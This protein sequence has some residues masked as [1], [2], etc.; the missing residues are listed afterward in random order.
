MTN[1]FY[2]IDDAKH[3]PITSDGIRKLARDGTIQPD[4]LLWRE[5]FKDWHPARRIKGLF[6][7][8]EAHAHVQSNPASTPPDGPPP[9]PTRSQTRD[10]PPPLPSGYAAITAD[11]EQEL[12]SKPIDWKPALIF[13]SITVGMYAVYTLFLA[14]AYENPYDQ[15]LASALMWSNWLLL[16]A[17]GLSVTFGSILF[18]RCWSVIPPSMTNYITPG[19]AVGQLFIPFYNFYWAFI[20]YP[21]LA[22][23]VNRA[24]GQSVRPRASTG[25]ALTLAILFVAKLIL[26]LFAVTGLGWLAWASWFVIWLLF[27]KDASAACEQ[28]RL[29]QIALADDGDDRA[30]QMPDEPMIALEVAAPEA[31]NAN[32][33][34]PPAR[35][36]P[37]HAEGQPAAKEGGDLHG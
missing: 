11:T 2:V 22:E 34:A 33:D 6:P 28:L 18:Y 26:L 20:A 24:S 3:G 37:E 12:P 15:D 27:F 8:L 25:L 29:R 35:K 7:D 13:N 1:W 19:K 5:G 21:K 9:I 31:D 4:T 30:Q 14:A 10:T 16:A 36:D 32:C 17:T 23:H